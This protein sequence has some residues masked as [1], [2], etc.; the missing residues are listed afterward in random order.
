MSDRWPG[1]ESPKEVLDKLI[2]YKE[3]KFDQKSVVGLAS[4]LS[5]LEYEE[6]RVALAKRIHCRTSVLDEEVKGQRKPGYKQAPGGRSFVPHEDERDDIPWQD[7]V[8]NDYMGIYGTDKKDIELLYKTRSQIIEASDPKTAFDPKTREKLI[9]FLN[10][11]EDIHPAALISAPRKL[12]LSLKDAFLQNKPKINLG[13]IVQFILFYYFAEHISPRFRAYKHSWLTRCKVGENDTWF[14]NA[15]AKGD[16]DAKQL[17][18]NGWHYEIEFDPLD[19]DMHQAAGQALC[20][21][22]EDVVNALYTEKDLTLVEY[23]FLCGRIAHSLTRYENVVIAE[24]ITLRYVQQ[25]DYMAFESDL[26][27]EAWWEKTSFQFPDLNIIDEDDLENAMD[28]AKFK[29]SDDKIER[30]AAKVYA[31]YTGAFTQVD[32]VK[33]IVQYGPNFLSSAV[34]KCEYVLNDIGKKYY[35]SNRRLVFP[36]YASDTREAQGIKREGNSVLL[37]NASGESVLRDLDD[38]VTFTLDMKKN[39]EHE[40]KPIFPP[41][42]LPRHLIDRVT[43]N[44]GSIP[45]PNLQCVTNTPTLLSDGTV[46]DTPGEF[47]AGVLFLAPKAEYPKIKQNPTK[48]D[49]IAALEQFKPIFEEFPFKKVNGEAWYKTPSYATVLAYCLTLAA[50]P[51]LN[52]A[53]PLFCASAPRA[54][55][56]KTLTLESSSMAIL[57]HKPTVVAFANEEE[58]GKTLLPLLLQQD[59]TVMIDNVDKPLQSAKLAMIITGNAMRDR[60]LGESRTVDLTNHSV[61]SATGNNLTVSGDLAYRALLITVDACCE[62]PEERKFS[63]NPIELARQEHP[64]LVVAA[65]TALLAYIRAGK[66]WGLD[67]GYLGGFESWDA[68]VSGCLVW[69]GYSDPLLTRDDCIAEDPERLELIELLETWFTEFGSQDVTLSEIA[70]KYDSPT[71]RLLLNQG[72]WDARVIAHQLRKVQDRVENNLRLSRGTKK[73][74]WCVSPVGKPPVKDTLPF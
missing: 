61:F 39:D 65:L 6:I 47:R 66:P 41:H 26:D 56:G 18:E 60:I 22:A 53:V 3:L 1:R 49:A 32:N 35:E 59:R 30:D 69:A 42:E 51:A 48:K 4:E 38:R 15:E 19:N 29:I 34:E 40:V 9:T 37:E 43:M 71:Y 72:R 31:K 20:S 12:I 14:M 74:S 54:R 27:F 21:L 11:L 25:I 63:F 46:H 33:R 28:Q 62:R 13:E 50:R 58:L 55:T 24:E 45:Y 36:C 67:R 16:A 52:C 57:G 5:P 10:N 64:K 23:F 17:R 68:L 7:H 2:L 73:Q 8:G 70:K 44:V